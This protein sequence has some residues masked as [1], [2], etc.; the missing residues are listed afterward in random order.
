MSFYKISNF[1]CSRVNSLLTIKKGHKIYPG[2][3]KMPNTDQSS[4]IVLFDGTCNLCSGAVQ[5]ILERDPD[6]RFKFASIQ[7]P[8]GQRLMKAHGFDP[9]DSG[10]FVLMEEGRVFTRSEAAL[11]V[12][13]KLSG[14]WPI[15]GILRFVPRT[16]RD[17]SYSAVAGRRYKWFGRKDSCII[18]TED[19][20]DR[21]LN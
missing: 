20:A 11:K 9:N 13:R 19:I 12:A 7:S 3:H 1:A 2:Y 15:L 16:L 5:F 14:A 21:F 17:L 10:T 4:A 8:A 6:G 18:P